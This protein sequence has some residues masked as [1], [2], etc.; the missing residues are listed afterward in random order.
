V[1]SYEKL[2]E[3]KN[4]VDIV[5]LFNRVRPSY[6]VSKYGDVLYNESM[7]TFKIENLNDFIKNIENNTIKKN[8]V[9]VGYMD[10]TVIQFLKNKNIYLSDNDIKLSVKAYKHST[11]DF[12]KNIDKSVD[13]NIIAN[14]Y[15][16]IKEPKNIFYDNLEKHK[17]LL[18]ISEYDNQ[19][20]KIIVN[21]KNNIITL[22][23]INEKDLNDKFLE[24]I[25]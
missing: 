4:G 14:I 19:L 18:Y 23:K 1:G 10:D 17:N 13:K 20:F 12:K 15:Q 3:F 22:G 8:D 16:H 9:I 2:Q 25:R 24:K 5:E 11:R 7:K 21:I 6:P